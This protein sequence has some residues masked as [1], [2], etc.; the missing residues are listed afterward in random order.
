MLLQR[1]GPGSCSRWSFVACTSEQEALLPDP[2]ASP[3]GSWRS[4]ITSDLIVQDS[5]SIG[6]VLV[7]ATTS[8][9]SKA[10]RERGAPFG[11]HER[12][13]FDDRH[14][15]APLKLPHPSPRIR[16]RRRLPGGWNGV[17]L[18]RQGSAALPALGNCRTGSADAGTD[19]ERRTT[20]LRGRRD[21]FPAEPLDRRPRGSHRPSASGHQR[22][23]YDRRHRSRAWR[24]GRN[25][26]LRPRFFFVASSEPGRRAASLAGVEPSA[27][28]LGGDGTVDGRTVTDA[29][30]PRIRRESPE[31]MPS[32]SSNPNGRPTAGC[33]SSAIGPNWWNLYRWQDGQ[34]IPL[35]PLA[36]E[37]GQPQW[38]FGKSTYAFADAKTIICDY[39]EDGLGKLASLD[40]ATSHAHVPSSCRSLISRKSAQGS[41]AAFRAA[42]RRSPFRSCRL[43]SRRKN[44]AFCERPRP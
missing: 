40:I 8:I 31:E 14:Q 15:S 21:R 37:F 33:I 1:G 20:P 25:P 17:L 35:C 11:S 43:T 3:F 22:G 9:G 34:A 10:D 16:R 19:Y 32:R 29:G 5:I 7:D 28:A 13:W 24:A 6:D 23:Q 4:P 41:Q 39:I 36:A 38:V 2:K 30:R 26:R 12:G 27:N 18:E 42:R 44:T